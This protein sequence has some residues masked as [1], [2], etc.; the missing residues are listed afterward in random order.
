M[1]ELRDI[2][3]VQVPGEKFCISFCPNEKNANVNGKVHGGISFLL[4][5]EAIGRYVTSLGRIGAVADANIHYY[6]PAELGKT[7]YA[8]VSERKTGKKLAIYLVELTDDTG[9]LLADT[10]FTVAFAD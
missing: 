8:A 10:L 7:L 3:I 5:D 9:K 6:R 2:D 1:F 4:C